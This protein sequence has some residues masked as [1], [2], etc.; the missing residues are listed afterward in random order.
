MGMRGV[1][2]PCLTWSPVNHY[3]S[4]HMLPAEI[5]VREG[6]LSYKKRK[7]GEEAEGNIGL[8]IHSLSISPSTGPKAKK[9]GRTKVR[10][11]KGSRPNKAEGQK[12]DKGHNQSGEANSEE[13]VAI[14][15]PPRLP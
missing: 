12:K 9:G 14:R 2:S 10:G 3:P 7:V 4:P 11:L 13:S 15:M 5:M 1:H 6:I 8:N